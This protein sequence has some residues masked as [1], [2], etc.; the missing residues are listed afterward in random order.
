M[1][2]MLLAM[3]PPALPADLVPLRTALERHGFQVRLAPP[4]RRNVYGL[5]EARSRTLWIA[6]VAFPLGI[7]RPTFLHEATHAAQSCPSGTL[8]LIG[9]QRKLD[10]VVS[11]EIRGILTTRYGHGNRAIE[12]EAFLVQAQPDGAQLLIDALGRRCR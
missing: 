3:P 1:G 10:P 5:F 7:G 11:Q 9:I 4:P 2:R 12:Q 8:S 6:P